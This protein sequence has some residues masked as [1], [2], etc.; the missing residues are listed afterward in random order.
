MQQSNLTNLIERGK[1]IML[2]SCNLCAFNCNV[3]R[4]IRIGRCGCGTSP[5]LALASIHKWEEPCISGKNG[6][7]TVFFSR[8]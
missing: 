8:M 2:E 7:G 1:F 6:S 4:N 5:K 3:N